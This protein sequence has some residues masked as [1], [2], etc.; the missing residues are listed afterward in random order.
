MFNLGGL[1]FSWKKYTIE[2]Y[3]NS[4]LLFRCHFSC[5]IDS[6]K[7][8]TSIPAKFIQ[9]VLYVANVSHNLVPV[10]TYNLVNGKF[11]ETELGEELS[12]PSA[13]EAQKAQDLGQWMLLNE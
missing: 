5:D 7:F 11:W 10:A 6:L 1:I 9:P 2:E 4:R 12:S 3:E 13:P 8:K